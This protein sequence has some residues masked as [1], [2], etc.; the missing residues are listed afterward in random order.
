MADFAAVS[1]S[2]PAVPTPAGKQATTGGTPARGCSSP[3]FVRESYHLKWL[4]S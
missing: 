1:V 4:K 2:V 3:N